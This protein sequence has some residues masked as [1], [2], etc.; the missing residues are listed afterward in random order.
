MQTLMYGCLLTWYGHFV[1]SKAFSLGLWCNLMMQNLPDTLKAFL[2][3]LTAK[4]K[5]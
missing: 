3:A 4:L 1:N 5:F 2:V